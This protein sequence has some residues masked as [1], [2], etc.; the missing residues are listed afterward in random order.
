[1][2]NKLRLNDTAAAVTSSE[3]N[4]L[5]LPIRV[6]PSVLRDYAEQVCFVFPKLF[7]IL[8][9]KGDLGV[10]FHC[11]EGSVKCAKRALAV[12]DHFFDRIDWTAE[13]DEFYF[14]NC[15][16]ES[17]K[18]Y[19]DFI[20]MLKVPRPELPLLLDVMQ[21]LHCDARVLKVFSLLLDF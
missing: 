5:S 17:V 14:D 11:R 20:H 12:S 16:R 7:P 13:H 21:F 19:L 3:P 9:T 18:I 2:M 6:S 8:L 15:S 10:I 4:L 1:M